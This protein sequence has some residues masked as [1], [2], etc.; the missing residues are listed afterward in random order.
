MVIGGGVIGASIA[1]HL[2]RLRFGRVAL[3]ERETLSAGSTGSSVASVDLLA[4]HPP[5]AAL[6]VR[7]LYL[8]QHCAEVYG[9]ECGWVQTGFAMLGGVEAGAG[10]GAHA[11]AGVVS[12]AGG[13]NP[14]DRPGGVPGPRPGLQPGRDSRDSWAPEGGYVDPVL[15]TSTFVGAARTGGVTV[16]LNEPVLGLNQVGGRVAGVTTSTGNIATGVVVAAAGPWCARVAH[17]AGLDLPIQVQRH[18]VAVLD[19]PPE[20]TPRVSVVDM[21]NLIY[22]RPETGGLT[23]GRLPGPG[24]GL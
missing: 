11:V 24:G 15:L 7:S 3:L 9:G 12:A 8:F 6:Q 14:G 22:A 16:R 2:A 20:T 21:T 17:M 18:S 23:L 10:A 5:V 19:C 13:Q 1:V 4:Q